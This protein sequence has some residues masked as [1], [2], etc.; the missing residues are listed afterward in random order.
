[1]IAGLH[2]Y[3]APKGSS[4]AIAAM[5]ISI[6]SSYNTERLGPENGQGIATSG[7]PNVGFHSPLPTGTQSPHRERVKIRCKAYP[8]CDHDVP[9]AGGEMFH[10]VFQLVIVVDVRWTV[11]QPL[12]LVRARLRFFVGDLRRELCQLVFFRVN[13]V[14]RRQV[15][16]LDESR[17]IRVLSVGPISLVYPLARCNR[18]VNLKFA[19]LRT[20]KKKK[21]PSGQRPIVKSRKAPSRHS[22]REQAGQW[23]ADKKKC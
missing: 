6:H 5:I 13:P 2:L 19:L 7:N 11:H 12:G 4:G 22:S 18:V 15:R 1:M 17:C 23:F 8:S 3:I 21:K 16:L 20:K 14:I 9:D 10:R